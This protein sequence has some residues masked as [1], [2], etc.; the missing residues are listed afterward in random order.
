MRGWLFRLDPEWAHGATL[1]LLRVA[2]ALPV[3]SPWLRR[4]SGIGKAS[5]VPV[6]LLGL[7]FRNSVGIAAGYDKDALGWRG[8]A[9]LG[10]GH[11]EIGTVTPRPQ[12]GNPRP[13]VFRLAEDRSLINRLGFPSRGAA[14]VANRLA[15]TRPPGFVLGVN[16][17]KQRDTPI[18]RAADDYEFLVEV[19]AARA[20]YLV[21]NISSPNTPEL[22]RLQEA[23][24]LKPLLARVRA[25]RDE[26][27]T[28]LGRRI[29]LWV[30][31][32]PDLEARDLEQTIDAILDSTVDGVIA[33]NTTVARPDLRSPLAAEPGGLSGAALTA[34]S[35]AILSRIRHHAGPALAL[36]GCGGVMT[37]ADHDAKRTA[38][39]SL[40]QI[41]TGLVYEG[42]ALLGRLLL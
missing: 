28:R 9:A 7:G 8:L 42:P 2:G 24:H 21:V 3:L 32:S 29:P 26:Q 19:F 18:E 10:F 40:V 30:K 38:G 12:P 1:N 4:L 31:L 23:R 13:R 25:C 22:R 39:A 5:G 11:V 41:Y 37:R 14:F 34:P 36:I 35:T 6:E 27:A 15:G 16:L 20:D 33:T 17:G